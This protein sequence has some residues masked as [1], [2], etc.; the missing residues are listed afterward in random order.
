MANIDVD[1]DV[2][3]ALFVRRQ[4]PDVTYNDVLRQ[5]LGL[6]PAPKA[7]TN[8][9][10]GPKDWTVKG[11]TF[12]EGTPFRVTYKGK[13]YEGKVEDGGLVIGATKYTTPSAAAHQITGKNVN[14]WRFWQCKLPGE[15]NWQTM[16]VIWNRTHR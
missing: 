1:F 3:K 8:G 13:T 2:E 4:S 15:T 5:L 14:G 11:V 9:Q 10:S 12:P 7:Q 16:E 6:G